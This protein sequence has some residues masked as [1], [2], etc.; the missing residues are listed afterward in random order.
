MSTADTSLLAEIAENRLISAI[1]GRLPVA[2]AKR[3]RMHDCDVELIELGLPTDLLAVTTD[4]VVE[5][6]RAGL[7]ADARTIGWMA[8]VVSLSDLAAAGARPVGVL[9]A[10]TFPPQWDDEF[11]YGIVEGMAEA[12]ESHGTGVLGGDVNEGDASLTTTALGLVDRSG[13]MTRRGAAPG[14]TVYSTGP[15]GLGNA[16]AFGRMVGGGALAPIEYRPR[17]RLPEAAVIAK[18]ATSCIDSSDGLLAA[19]DQVARVNAVGICL[20]GEVSPLLHP[21]ALALAGVAG[22]PPVAMLAGVHGDFELCF[23][24]PK[25]REAAFLQD[26]SAHDHPTIRIGHV[27]ALKDGAT[28]IWA[29]VHCRRPPSETRSGIRRR[30]PNMSVSS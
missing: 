9:D 3:H 28:V 5:E 12:L 29:G 11:R 14:D 4:S 20:P 24:V 7:Y 26:M 16:Y 17:A 2:A 15:A 25:A 21:A 23:T 27:A 10:V 1:A 19:V 18:Y 22:V 8:V 13:V 6:I 30:R